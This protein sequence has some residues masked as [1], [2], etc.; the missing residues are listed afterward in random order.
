MKTYDVN[1]KD[2]LA[3][4]Q[5]QNVISFDTDHGAVP[6]NTVERDHHQVTFEVLP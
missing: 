5:W 6:V 3:R 1:T 4:Q 2:E